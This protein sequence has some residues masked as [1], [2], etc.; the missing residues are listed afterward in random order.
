MAERIDIGDWEFS[1]DV[2]ILK[3]GEDQ[4]ALENRA[5][6]AL[7]LLCCRHGE[8]VTHSEFVDVIWQGRSL[9]ANSV[10]VVIADLRRALNDDAR[11]PRYIE[12]VSKRGYRIIAPLRFSDDKPDVSEQEQTQTR[13]FG[14]KRS[15]ILIAVV[16][17]VVCV[18]TIIVSAVRLNSTPNAGVVFVMVGAFENDTHDDQYA[19]L[20][21]AMTELVAT[22]LMRH[23]HVRVAT[24]SGA[25]ILVRGRIILWDGQVAVGLHAENIETGEEVWSGM[26][27]GP[28][29]QLPLQVRQLFIVLADVVQDL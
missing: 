15:W 4:K 5:A 1:P 10:A 21:P 2:A 6:A 7:E 19:V 12:T 24:R 22:E 8:L 3:L 29:S 28:E 17:V 23:E 11:A 9:S 13:I 27:K 16:F 26:A 14:F 25:S 20:S 18:S